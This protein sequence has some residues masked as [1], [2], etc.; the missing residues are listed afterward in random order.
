[1][2]QSAWEVASSTTTTPMPLLTGGAASAGV[3][4]GT[5]HAPQRT[6]HFVQLQVDPAHGR[7]S[8]GFASIL[9]KCVKLC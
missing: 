8:K 7:H 9:Q 6:L 2:L 1:M 4:K 3:L 5:A